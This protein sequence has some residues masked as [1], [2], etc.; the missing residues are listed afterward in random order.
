MNRYEILELLRLPP[1]SPEIAALWEQARGVTDSVF[2]KTVFQR[3]VVEFSSFCRKNCH[4]CGLRN[5]N[6]Q[7][8]RFRLAEDDV[9]SAAAVGAS[10]GVGTIVLQ[11]GEDTALDPYV[12]GS[13]ITQIKDQ[14]AVAVTLSLGDYDED[15][16][17]YWRDCGAD[18]YL[19][20][21]ETTDAALHGQYRPGQK[22]SERMRRIETLQKL[23]F[24]TG[25]GLITGLPGRLPHM[26]VEDILL[27][28]SLGLDMIACGPFVP[29]PQTP[30]GGYPA[31][32]VQEA[33][34][35]N[36]IVRLLNPKAH[37]PAT[38][39]LD[40][41]VPEGRILGLHA[42]AN[43]VMPSITPESVRK[44]YAIYPGKNVSVTSIAATVR[45]LQERISKVGYFVSDA[46][47]GKEF[48][49]SPK[50]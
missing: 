11:A 17:T 30:L 48:F 36:A 16:Y 37:I 4:Y 29:H 1:D 8:H 22:V 14:H 19:L 46:R 45:G 35:V 31:G 10:L 42:G 32:S 21:V 49:S 44:S 43:V 9:L 18:R 41:L 33:L 13:L 3:G 38:S 20:K 34:T 25:S 26:V 15:T 5:A 40:A 28:S 50:M 27:L 23:G 39:A 6:S 2:G 12:V 47:G 24:E 7:L